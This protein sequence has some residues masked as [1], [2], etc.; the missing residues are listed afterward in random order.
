MADYLAVLGL[1]SNLPGDLDSPADQVLRAAQA[2]DAAEGITVECAS[3]LFAT[4]PWGGVSQQE[5]R[6]ATVTIRTGLDPLALLDRCQQVEAQGGRVREVRWGP[7]TVDVDVLGIFPD[8]TAPSMNSNG[9]WG[10]AL[11]VPHPYVSER[12][13][14]LEPWA[15][16]WPDAVVGEACVRDLREDLH[17]RDPAA[18]DGL[19]KVA[20]EGWDAWTARLQ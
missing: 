19:R 6:N 13:F 7:R 1:G 15:N 17:R 20:H 4:P 14:V 3:G 5:F 10:D 2:L 12:A 18:W 8:A 9:R 16:M 11:I